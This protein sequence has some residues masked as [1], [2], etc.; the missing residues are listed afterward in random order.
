[1]RSSC[2]ICDPTGH[3][4]SIVRIRIDDALKYNKEMCSTEYLGCNIEKF[5]EHIELQ[6]KQGMSWENHSEWH[7]DHKIPLKYKQDFFGN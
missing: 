3:L 7:I 4:G 2:K 6:F 5:R 1:M